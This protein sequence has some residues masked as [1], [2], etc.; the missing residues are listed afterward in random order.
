M[1]FLRKEQTLCDAEAIHTDFDDLSVWQFIGH[2][3]NV[4]IGSVWCTIEVSANQ[5]TALRNG[6]EEMR[7]RGEEEK[8]DGYTNI[9]SKREAE[10]RQTEATASIETRRTIRR[11]KEGVVSG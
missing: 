4:G 11:W 3:G 5:T 9:S 1:E 7:R 2:S 10:T 6:K 8:G